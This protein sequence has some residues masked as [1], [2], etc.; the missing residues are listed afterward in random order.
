LIYS[1]FSLTAVR[2]NGIVVEKAQLEVVEDGRLVEVRQR[3]QIVGPKQEI[4]VPEI[5]QI[6]L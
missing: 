6:L 1:P 5:R 2:V 3:S 4:R